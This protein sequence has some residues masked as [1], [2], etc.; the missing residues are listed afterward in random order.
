MI[1]IWWSDSQKLQTS[2]FTFD[3]DKPVFLVLFKFQH[4]ILFE[5]W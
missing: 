1:D 3:E 4:L 2:N 5:L